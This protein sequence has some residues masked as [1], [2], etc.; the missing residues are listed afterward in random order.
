MHYS[1]VSFLFSTHY[2]FLLT[3]ILFVALFFVWGEVHAAPGINQQ[4]HYQ[5]ILKDSSGNAVS[6]G[7]YDIVFRMYT[8]SSGGSVLWTGTYTAANGNA[9]TVTNGVFSVLL[10]SGTGNSLSSVDFNQDTLYVGIT[11]GSDSE[12]TPRQRVGA[13]AQAF[14]ANQLNGVGLATSTLSTGD[15]LYFNGTDLE[16]LAAGSNGQVLKLASGIPSWAADISGGT[17]FFATSSDSLVLYPNDTNDV[18][19]LGGSA[20]T[21]TGNIFETVG[22]ALIGGALTAYNTVSGPSFAATSTTASSTVNLLDVATAFELGS[23]Y[24]TDLTG[25]GLVLTGGALTVD[26]SA[27][28]SL[29]D[30]YATTTDA[31]L[32]GSSNVYWTQNRFDTALLATSS[33]AHLSVGTSSVAL[34]LDGFSSSDYLTLANWYATT[35]DALSEG[36]NN[37][38]W[39]N[40]RFDNRLSATTTLPNLAVLEGVTNLIATNATTTNA[41]STNLRVSGTASLTNT[42]NSGTLS[43][44]GNTT[45]INASTTNVTANG[46]LNVV[47]DATFTSATSSALYSSTLGLNSEYFSDF[48][49]TGLVNSGGVLSV[50]SATFFLLSDWFGTTTAPQLATLEGVTSLIATN[51]TSTNL[52]ISGSLDTALSEGSIA[53]IETNGLLNGDTSKLRWDNTNNRFGVGT[54]SPGA[55]LAV[56]G[57]GLFGGSV[58]SEGSFTGTSFS[59]GTLRIGATAAGEIDTAS[60][61]LILDSAGGSVSIDDELTVSATTTLSSVLNLSNNR[62]LNV[63]NPTESTDAANKDYVDSF[64]QG[65]VWQEPVLTSGSTTPPSSPSSGDRH[66]VGTGATGAWANQSHK[67]AEWNGSSWAFA[68]STVGFSAFVSGANQQQTYNG[69]EW[70]ELGSGTSHANLSGLQGGN[71]SDQYYHLNLSDYQALTDVN[72]QLTALHTDSSPTFTGLTATRATTTN[73]TSTHFYTSN[74]SLANA[75]SVADGGTG[76]TT[77]EAGGLFFYDGSTFV[78]DSGNLYWDTANNRLGVGTSS[79]NESLHVVGNIKMDSNLGVILDGQDRPLIT[80]GFDVFTSG[81]Y[82]GVG[83][84]GVF[85][86]PGTLTFGVPNLSG[87]NFQF[88]RYD[89]DSSINEVVM[90]INE[91]GDVNVGTTTLASARVSIQATSTTDILNLFETDGIEVLTVLESGNVGIGTSSPW[92]K[93]SVSGSGEQNMVIHSTDTSAVGAYLTNSVSSWQ[94]YNAGGNGGLRFNNGSD[95]LNIFSN[96]N[97]SIGSQNAG[98]RLAVEGNATIGAGYDTVSAPVNGLLVE[99]TIGIGSTSPSQKLSIEG[100]IGLSSTTPSVTEYALYNQGGTLYWNGNVMNTVGDGSEGQT[101]IY[102]AF[103]V[104][105]ATS[106]IAIDTQGRVG[107]GRP[108]PGYPFE[109]RSPATTSDDI[110]I[111]VAMF[112]AS[113]AGNEGASVIFAHNESK[114]VRLR[115]DDMGGFGGGLH[116]DVN[117]APG[118]NNGENWLTA[119]TFASNGYVGIGTTSPTYRL[120]VEGNGNERIVVESTGNANVELNLVNA[121]ST[122]A[123]YNTASGNGLRFF[124]DEDHVTFANDGNVGIGTTSPDGK[125]HIHQT[126]TGD[127]FNLYDG[128]TNVFTVLDGGNVGIGTSTPSGNLVINGTT[129]QNLFQIATSTHQSIFIVNDSGN[130]G[131]GTPSPQAILHIDGGSNSFVNIEGDNFSTLNLG[132]A[133][134]VDVGSIV[135]THTTDALSFKT[136]GTEQVY[137]NSSGNVGIGTSS[138][139]GRL[140]VHV[141]ETSASVAAHNRAND[142]VVENND[143]AGITILAPND[144]RASLHFGN[145]TDNTTAYVRWSHSDDLMEIATDD[146]GGN[147]AFKTGLGGEVMRILDGQNVAIGRQA[148]DA[149]LTVQTALSID[150][151]NLLEAGGAEVFTVLESGNVGIGTS[152]PTAILHVDNGENTFINVQ[153]STTSTV[154][155]GDGESENV[156]SISYSHSSNALT[157]RANNN[158]R[159]TIDSVGDVGIGTADPDGKLHV[160]AGASGASSVNTNADDL[161]VEHNATG[162]ISILTPDANE[163]NI[164]F[165]SASDNLGA[166]LKW[167]HNNNL[168]TL[169]TDRTDADIIFATG[170]Q[171][172]AMRILD[173]GFVGIGDTT[174]DDL[175]NVHSASGESAVAITALGS[176]DAL[177][178]FEL[179][180]STPTF[181]VGV[182][183]S[184]S[185]KFKVSGSALGTNDR[186]VIDSSGNTS[187]GTSTDDGRLVVVQNDA[188]DIFNLYDGTTN[189]F[190]VTDGGNVG[191]G[192]STPDAPLVVERS[193]ADNVL[194]RFVDSS[195]RGIE[196]DGWSSGANID[197]VRANDN[198]YIGRDT[199]LGSLIIESGIVGIGTTSPTA[200]LSLQGGIG[201]SSSQLYLAA[202]GNVG[203][204]TTSPGQVL[205]IDDGDNSVFRIEGDTW[206]TINFADAADGDVGR[207]VYNHSGDY[208]V[209]GVGDTDELR[210]TDTGDLCT[211]T[212]GDFELNNCSS[213]EHLKTNIQDIAYGLS[214]LR[215]LRPV[216]F[217]WNE[218][219]AITYGY[220]TTTTVTG[221]I[222]QELEEIF[223]EWVHE[224]QLGYKTIA[225]DYKF[226]TF[227]AIQDLADIA[228]GTNENALAIATSTFPEGLVPALASLGDVNADNDTF[229]GKV[230]TRFRT[231][232][233]DATNGITEFIAGTVRATDQLCVGDTCV[234][235]DEL[236]A[237]LAGQAVAAAG[238]AE[239]N[240]DTTPQETQTL[241]E[242]IVNGN[243]P[244]EID[245]GASYKDL[246]AVA[247]STDQTI[248]NFG[249]RTYFNGVEDN[250]PTLDTSV[251]GEHQITYRILD[252]EETVLAEATRTVI[253]T[254]PNEPIEPVAQEEGTQEETTIE[255]QNE[256]TLTTEEA[257]D[258]SR[259]EVNEE[260]DS[261]E[262]IEGEVVVE[263][264]TETN[265]EESTSQEET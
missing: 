248:V 168:A 257:D 49:G 18:L 42:T 240:V 5:G 163:S 52:S 176:A 69:T 89:A 213:D 202:N 137:I 175:L 261:E 110:N 16:R 61:N 105:V 54:S 143:D 254:D 32:E 193:S 117:D 67:I 101:L 125:L 150:I 122:W 30:W 145:E 246:G 65:L 74:L 152:S 44:T 3:A 156:G 56:A 64:A 96:G 102:N 129:G 173:T 23:D 205:H 24:I 112:R 108:D 265:E 37:L 154:N 14:N 40:T 231:W 86:E 244:A 230:L 174:P 73:A 238:G 88:A 141:G 153:A 121:S 35:T 191:I 12:M 90:F 226:L 41:T 239:T 123:V 225:P 189:V 233:A 224:D 187:I 159:M 178:K 130:V 262:M 79:P 169:G 104:P 217:Q 221:L 166:F 201:V 68:S 27:F 264:E 203:I 209:F 107:I 76:T 131:I 8:A 147:I 200:L 177:L 223:P 184:D 81:N 148:A 114:H 43:V 237:L 39:T 197:P 216:S 126:G 95:R 250:T 116:I 132:D 45:L 220:S 47:G 17:G 22:S 149:R 1:W 186:L 241:V 80:R 60:G 9:V 133:N 26:S 46:Y 236:K 62:I 249:V 11:V 136:N 229:L 139:D 198:I 36:A 34:T 111:D 100:A 28:L 66:I 196:I 93:L 212:G 157:F 260:T 228:L 158:D 199:D 109:V 211:S 82:N 253:V 247:S 170:L 75:L 53:F 162:G 206:S 204:G 113:N 235:E 98:S 243:N 128:T 181:T 134:A 50:D 256:E 219:A 215:A 48:T 142:L 38:Y 258:S 71:G 160:H 135:Y 57:N 91:N 218:V 183:N 13:V 31:V 259:L 124:Q 194:A 59:N 207:I 151:L 106:T 4:I 70:V 7:N 222:A 2:R 94:M 185:D 192:T 63:A 99:G 208:F 171:S 165:G 190:S 33:L 161:V 146:S 92:Q 227:N 58:V 251:S 55:P 19:V 83:R 51:A 87:K 115:S 188:A 25:T 214:E 245:L 180:D 210:L 15:I 242:I 179:T 127:I 118:S 164:F 232:F 77:A 103:G 85:M 234:N 182:D 172:E 252:E 21:T 6:N 195:Y 97:V 140:H 84:W 72:A 120:N 138:P 119:L 20:T 78:Q 10:G 255:G 167:S 144:K 29:S 263:N 155:L